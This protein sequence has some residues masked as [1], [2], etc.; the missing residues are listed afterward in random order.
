M[1][2]VAKPVKTINY[3]KIRSQYTHKLHH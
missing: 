1:R 2:E 3:Y